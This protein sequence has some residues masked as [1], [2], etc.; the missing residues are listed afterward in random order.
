MRREREGETNEGDVIIFF[1]LFWFSLIGLSSLSSAIP[2]SAR[3][4]FE[5]RNQNFDWMNQQE[6][7]LRR[8]RFVSLK[9]AKRDYSSI[10]TFRNSDRRSWS[11]QEE[12]R[13]RM[14]SRLSKAEAFVKNRAH[15][16]CR[17][18]SGISKRNIN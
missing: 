2:F 1:C 6:K 7:H 8:E 13:R 14:C 16:S 17:A 5:R 12:G 10:D 11:E 9:N 4:L 3:A 18:T 15:S